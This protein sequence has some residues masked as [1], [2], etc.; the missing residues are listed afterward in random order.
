[1]KYRYLFIVVLLLSFSACEKV[2]E[3][4]GDITESLLVV[5]SIAN[6]GS[7]LEVQVYYSRFFLESSGDIIIGEDNYEQ[8]SDAQV[9]LYVNGTFLENIE[10]NG[11]TYLST[12]IPQV[13]DHLELKVKRGETEV[14]S[15][16]QMLSPASVVKFDT[17]CTDFYTNMIIDADYTGGYEN[18]RYDTIGISIN[19]TYQVTVWL[20]DSA[21]TTDYYYATGAIDNVQVDG[22]KGLGYCYYIVDDESDVDINLGSSA[23]Y[24][25]AVSPFFSDGQINGK[26]IPLTFQVYYVCK[27]YYDNAPETYTNNATS[28]IILD[29]DVHRI[30]YD[31]YMYLT[32]A[33]SAADINSG[34]SMF[35]EPVQVYNN[36]IGG[37]G[38]FGSK[39]SITQSIPFK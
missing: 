18:Y 5:N 11:T 6:V 8:L 32:T 4:K 12:Y 27:Q 20:A 21:Q 37:V 17:V 38:I 15:E 10:W 19:K 33:Q 31:Y 34:F 14:S 23:T 1:M 25:P 9:Q 2:I 24:E 3:F 16:T 39:S 7:E 35:T 29:I 36:I 13:G 26:Q 28:S 22:E 30:S